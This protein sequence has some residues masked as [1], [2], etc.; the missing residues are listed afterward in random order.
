M[1]PILPC[2]SWLQKNS[3]SGLDAAM[4]VRPELFAH[5]P[6]ERRAGGRTSEEQLQ[7][8]M[9]LTENGKKPIPSVGWLQGNGYA[10][11]DTWLR[12]HPEVVEKYG[13]DRLRQT[14]EERLQLVMQLTENGKKPIPSSGWLRGN[15]YT[16]LDTWL[17]KHPE[18]VEKYGQDRLRQTSEEQLQLVMQLT[19]NGK[20]PI[21]HRRWLIDNGYAALDTWLYK[22]PEVVEKYG[23]DRLRRTSEEQLQLVMQLTENGEK[24]IPHRRWLIDNG[25]GGLDAWLRKHPEVVEKYGQDR[26]RQTS[27]EHLQLVMQLT[28]N[29]EKPIPGSG[30]LCGNGYTGLDS[31]IRKH[32]EVVEKY[33]RDWAGGRTSE[34][35]LQLVMQ[36]TENGKKPIPGYGWLCGNG[37]RALDAWLRKHP[38]VVEKYGRD[39]L[40][41]GKRVAV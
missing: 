2:P 24:P 21:P 40:R 15:G 37:Y 35:Q 4:R 11:L 38:E 41:A 36:L 1:K 22:H 33:G 28:E 9:Q 32:P 25:Y 34:E 19:E 23:Q 39:R 16:G 7:L 29:G 17:Y 20:K 31:W 27:E 30:W 26:L 13:Q 18:V 10:A 12:K 6:Q 14:P 3:Y 5:I 8:V